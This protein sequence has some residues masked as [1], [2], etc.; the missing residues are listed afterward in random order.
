MQEVRPMSALS[1]L[2]FVSLLLA[3]AVIGGAAAHAQSFRPAEQAPRGA[4]FL[5]GVSIPSGLDVV[6]VG[7]TLPFV[8]PIVLPS[9]YFQGSSF[10][11]SAVQDVSTRDGTASA[12]L[13]TV[14]ASSTSF[15]PELIE[16]HDRITSA[17]STANASVLDTG[18]SGVFV[19][20]DPSPPSFPG[21]SFDV[22][23][24]VSVALSVHSDAPVNGFFNFSL[25]R[26]NDGSSIAAYS[27]RED[28]PALDVH[29]LVLQLPP[30]P[31]AISAEMFTGE[32]FGGAHEYLASYSLRALPQGVPAV[33]EP[34]TWTL[35]MIGLAV[36]AGLASRPRRQTHGA[37]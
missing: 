5:G 16:S 6:V 2:R 1:S 9:G 36:T 31:Y 12:H 28:T 20:D 35:L 10:L 23:T 27:I 19:H 4:D 24:P 26:R 33:P 18:F 8:T 30:G 3:L 21:V 29:D 14:V 7:D 11:D 17:A 22:V 25:V 37:G 34:T 32:H 13:E 15:G